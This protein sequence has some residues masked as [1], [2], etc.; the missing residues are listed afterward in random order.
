[1]PAP[2]QVFEPCAILL[3]EAFTIFNEEYKPENKKDFMISLKTKPNFF[4]TY[5]GIEDAI[6]E[7]L[8]K[9]SMNIECSIDK[10]VPLLWTIC[11]GLH[12]THQKIEL[13]KDLLIKTWT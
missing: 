3:S 12:D 13:I 4:K 2:T 1:M 10:I 9:L 7:A 5:Q 6:K 11:M 8:S